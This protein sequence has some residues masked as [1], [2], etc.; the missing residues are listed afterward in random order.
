MTSNKPSF[1]KIHYMLRPRKQVE[2]KI[3][4]E[5]LQE[6]QTAL[7]IDISKYQYLGLGSIYYY[8]FILFNKYLNITD[9]ISLDKRPCVQRFEFN[10]PFDFVR[11]KNQSST[12]FLSSQS[13]TTDMNR[14]VWFDYDSRLILCNGRKGRQFAINRSILEDVGV[15][16]TKS[17]END[18]F[19]LSVSL[20]LPKNTFVTINTR[21]EFL[22]QFKSHLSGKYKSVSSITSG[23][24]CHI[25]QNVLL[26]TFKNNE[27]NQTLRFNKLFSFTYGDTTP[28]Y[29]LGGI[30]RSKD[31]EP[32]ALQSEF[33]QPDEDSIIDIDVPMLTYREKLRLDQ[34]VCFLGQQLRSVQSDDDLIRLA[35]EK[36]GFEL[37]CLD[38]RNY[39]KY[40][41]Y[42]PQYYEGII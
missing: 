19:I 25:V 8:D 6:L 20:D 12:Q 38:L 42:Y 15:L 21:N 34:A 13:A 27:I 5:L 29:T 7:K 41:R 17:N 23:D 2:R 4:I 18:L 35:I 40:Y 22:N 28:M 9:M 32:A 1:L 37:D 10:I 36:L 14:L 3:V 24:Y 11:F 33:Y 16:T 30:Y 39:V 26:N 31:S